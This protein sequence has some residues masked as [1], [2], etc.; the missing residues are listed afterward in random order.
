MS[1][2]AKRRQEASERHRKRIAHEEMASWAIFGIIL[3]VGYLIFQQIYP[4]IQ[5]VLP[6]LGP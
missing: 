5:R 3:V 4:L 2:W 6:M 1:F